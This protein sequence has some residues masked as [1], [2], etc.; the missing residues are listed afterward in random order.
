MNRPGTAKILY[1]SFDE[2]PGP[3]GACRHIEAFVRA[4]GE[5]LGSVLLLTPGLVDRGPQLLAAGVQHEVLGCPDLNPI[6]RARTFRA[7]LRER[8][9]DE[10]FDIIHF[11]SI[12]EGI[13]LIEPAVR[14]SAQVVYEV[15]GF[16]S[17]EMKYHY[18]ALIDNSFLKDKFVDQELACL[19]AADQI[20]TVSQVNRQ[21][22]AARWN[23]S[24]PIQ[25]IPNGV[26]TDVF[27]FRSPRG[28]VES[29]EPLLACYVGTLTAWQGI[30][31]AMEALS[32]VLRER[33]MELTILGAGS[34]QRLQVLQQLVLKLGIGDH[35]RFRA[36]TESAAVV[37][38]LHS[39]HIT[40]VPLL[41]VDRNTQQGCCPLKMLE[42]MSAGCP[43]I[44]SDL[45]VIQEL[46]TPYEHYLPSRPGDAHNLKNVI[47]E[48][49][50]DF[51]STTHRAQAARHHV[52]NNLTWQ[53]AT[54]MLLRVYDDLLEQSK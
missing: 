9:R 40:L 51:A 44:A 45:P 30:E 2:V 17:I 3:K 34:R 32:L 49:T 20:I 6:G 35:V 8:I 50:L 23:A 46:A 43:I 10:S 37:D 5:R 4:A 13:P 19:S 18:R 28:P 29:T 48:S 33:P 36:P 26:D 41:A 52:V 38:L 42:A 7:K 1:T 22:I 21:S 31:T 24:R 14:K 12:F 11:R 54:Q 25:V 53:H 47:L 39:S 27:A 15:N 16:P